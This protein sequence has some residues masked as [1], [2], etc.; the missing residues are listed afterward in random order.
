MAA[1]EIVLRFDAG[2]LL[3]DGVAREADGVPPAFRWDERVGRWRAPAHS[4]RH[5]VKQ[6]IRRGTTYEDRARAY[7][8]FDFRSTLAIEPRPY[9]E[10][11]VREWER[12]ERC[13]VVVLPTGAGKSLVAQMAIERVGR[14]SLVVVPTIDL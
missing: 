12:S 7:D 11:A 2:T 4:Y 5:V 9:Q 13:G 1:D 6:L 14:S 10:E 8:R 3:L